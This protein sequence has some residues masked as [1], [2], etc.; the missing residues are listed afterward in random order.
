M[1]SW[2]VLGRAKEGCCQLQASRRLAME[3]LA[4]KECVADGFLAQVATTESC[5]L[6]IARARVSRLQAISPLGPI[7]LYQPTPNSWPDREAYL[8]QTR[9]QSTMYQ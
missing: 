3:E 4:C 9:C 5:E 1:V 8:N 2:V 6:G 7:H